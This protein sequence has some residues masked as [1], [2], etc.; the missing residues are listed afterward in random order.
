VID[1]SILLFGI[2]CFILGLLVASFER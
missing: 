2:S 1:C